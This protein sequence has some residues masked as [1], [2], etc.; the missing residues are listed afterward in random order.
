MTTLISSSDNCPNFYISVS[1]TTLISSSDNCPNFYISVSLTTLISS[2]DNCPTFYI[3]VSLT[4]LISSSND[5]SSNC[6]NF[7][8]LYHW[9]HPFLQIIVQYHGLKALHFRFAGCAHFIFIRRKFNTSVHRRYRFVSCDG[10]NRH[11]INARTSQPRYY[12]CSYAT[13]CVT[14]WEARLG[15]NPSHHTRNLIFA[16]GLIGVP[17]CLCWKWTGLLKESV[18]V[19]T[20]LAQV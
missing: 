6:P 7:Y 5:C 3:S 18:V 20:Q 13:I 12:S 2:S 19:G 16:H 11:Y 8:V 10:H 1:L 9:L 17:T 14:V 15:R 4:T